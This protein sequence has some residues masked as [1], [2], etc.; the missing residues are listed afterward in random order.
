MTTATEVAD[1]EAAA[2]E[3]AGPEAASSLT[4]PA[5]LRGWTWVLLPAAIANVLIASVWLYWRANG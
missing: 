5:S 1:P 3:T 2:A 4:P